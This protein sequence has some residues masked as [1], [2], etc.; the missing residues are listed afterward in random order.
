M[1]LVRVFFTIIV[2][3]VGIPL[4]NAQTSF[5]KKYSGGAF[6]QG[7]GIVQLPDSSFAVTG[8]SSSFGVN[9]GQAFLMLV[10][11]SGNHLWTKD[12]GGNGTEMGQ[13][14]FYEPNDGY[15]I[16]GHSNSTPAEGYDFFALKTDENGVQEWF[17]N[18]GTE[19]WER[20]WDARRLSDGTYFLVGETGGVTTDKKDVYMLRLDGQGDSI[21]SKTISTS[22]NDIAYAIDTL[23]DT[24]VV[25]GGI[26]GNN[27]AENGFLTEVHYDGTILWKNFYDQNG[28]T[29]VYDIQTF[30]GEIFAAGS[31]ITSSYELRD[32]WFLKTDWSGA[33]VN[34]FTFHYS[35]DD[36][37]ESFAI[38]DVGGMYV[39]LSSYSPEL[40]PFS[41]GRDVFINKFHTNLYFNSFAQAY[42]GWNNDE[43]NQMIPTIEGGIA[44]VGT[45]S[46]NREFD[47]E[48]SDVMVVKI[49]PNDEITIDADKEELVKVDKNEL[50][51]K[52]EPIYPNPTED[53]LFL[54]E[55]IQKLDITLYN[56]LGLILKKFKSPGDM[57]SLGS[58]SPG[59]YW[60][61]VEVEGEQ[62]FQ[63]IVKK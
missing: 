26:H 25:V 37:H 44:F 56:S 54:P 27:G 2:V 43:T 16:F 39:S 23:T 52:Y 18:Y 19:N 34:D 53:K 5:Y 61:S 3:V 31:I 10:D 36:Y 4:V 30:G 33:Q 22:R 38:K 41:G 45:A 11:S 1:E 46:D 9:S 49:G 20:L 50:S 12:Y 51:T 14:I 29:E 57:I 63:K 32:L 21:W 48:G 7:R 42:S 8:G 40:D 17:K 6:D 60:L 62:Y 47:S 24:T 13:R 59:F 15:F 28:V 58:F 55:K 35:E